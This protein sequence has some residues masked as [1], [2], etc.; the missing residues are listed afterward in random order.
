MNIIIKF[1]I[2]WKTINTPFKIILH[3]KNIQRKKNLISI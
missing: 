2:T 3:Q 1:L